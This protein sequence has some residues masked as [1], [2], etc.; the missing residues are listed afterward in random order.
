MR[1]SDAEAATIEQTQWPMQ[2]P[3]L[4][5]NCSNDAADGILRPSRN[6]RGT[7]HNQTLTATQPG[8]GRG[9]SDG[10]GRPRTGTRTDNPQRATQQW[11]TVKR[12]HALL[13][14]QQQL[15]RLP[16]DTSPP[17]FTTTMEQLLLDHNSVVGAVDLTN[18]LN[19]IISS[20]NPASPQPAPPLANAITPHRLSTAGHCCHG[21]LPRS[22]AEPRAAVIPRQDAS[23][24][25]NAAIFTTDPSLISQL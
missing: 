17:P 3:T 9:R 25:W 5:T 19:N 21:P 13:A 1:A 12:S 8:R 7:A 22:S 15:S 4:T 24:Q 23:C 2:R 16:R 20:V 6:S 11:W 18:S 14:H 10:R